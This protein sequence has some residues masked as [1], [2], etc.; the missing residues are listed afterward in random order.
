MKRNL[1]LHITKI[2]N[3][4]RAIKGS[5]VTNLIMLDLPFFMIEI[6]LFIFYENKIIRWFYSIIF[7]YC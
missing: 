7:N 1:F 3:S 6:F 5:K 4:Q 2:N